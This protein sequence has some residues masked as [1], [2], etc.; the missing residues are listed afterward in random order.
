MSSGGSGNTW[1]PGQDIAVKTRNLQKFNKFTSWA[2]IDINCYITMYSVLVFS[3]VS[4]NCDK[5]I[6]ISH[7]S[8]KLVLSVQT[9]WHCIF[10]LHEL[11]YKMKSQLIVCNPSYIYTVS[12]SILFRNDWLKFAEC[13]NKSLDVVFPLLILNLEIFMWAVL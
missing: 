3:M 4:L 1:T 5:T 12:I 13:W 9:D 10:F 11:Y 7:L 8:P 2:F 6:F